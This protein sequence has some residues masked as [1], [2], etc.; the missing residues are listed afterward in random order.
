VILGAAASAIA[1]CGS[2]AEA[3][4]GVKTPGGLQAEKYVHEKCSSDHMES[5]D[6]NG[7]GKADIQRVLDGSGH[8]LCRIV[9]LDHDGKADMYEFFDGSGAIRR[10]EFCYDQSGTV[11]A[12]ELYQ[13]GKLAQRE[14]DI[15]GQH[16]ID[17]WDWFDVN[18]PAD[19]KTGRPAHPTRRE[20]D[21]RGNG[22]VDQWWSWEGDKIT[23]AVDRT[24][25]GKPDPDATIVLAG[26]AAAAAAANPDSV[27]AA[28]DAGVSAATTATSSAPPVAAASQPSAIG[29]DGGPR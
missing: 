4:A 23:I 2:G 22:K 18:A 28:A 15:S 21:T 20:R 27:S 12:I 17:T 9:D 1:G 19:A 6:T 16:R 7:D 13:G 11:N 24:G 5:L 25:D 29:S 8:E 10:R 14:Y 26:S 3:S